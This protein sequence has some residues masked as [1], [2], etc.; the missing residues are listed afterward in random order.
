[1]RI[2]KLHKRCLQWETIFQYPP[3]FV[4]SLKLGLGAIACFKNPRAG[5]SP[6]PSGEERMQIVPPVMTIK[7]LDSGYCDAVA[8]SMTE[9]SMLKS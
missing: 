4:P 5:T 8:E 2:I 3:G 9:E 6:N 1:M 7:T